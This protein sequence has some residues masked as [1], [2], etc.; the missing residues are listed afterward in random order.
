VF[1]VALLLA[2]ILSTNAVAQDARPASGERLKAVLLAPQQVSA[3]KLRT[4]AADGN[5]AVVIELGGTAEAARKRARSAA[6]EVRKSPLEL[7]YWIEIARNPELA[8]AHPEWMAS[9]QGHQE[10]RRLFKDPPK[11]KADEVVKVFPWVPILYKEAFAAQLERVEK[12]LAGMPQPKGVF[13]ND[14]QGAPSACGC[15]NPLCRWTTDYG[16]IRTATPLGADASAR[17]VAAVEKLAPKADVIPVWVTEC[18]E[19]DGAKDG[20]CAGVGCF[21]GICW[22][23]YT[24]QLRPVA[25]HSSRLGVLVPFRAFQRDLPLYG[26]KGGWIGHAVKTFQT[27]PPRHKGKAIA[28]SRLITVLQGW[29]VTD[30]DVAAQL[31]ESQRAGVGGT[32]VSEVKIDQSFKPR[33]VKWK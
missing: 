10:W 31:R 7:Y 6:D 21:K 32:I 17:F 18:E 11:P 28:A 23:A 25:E 14:L 2:A 15:G 4:L 26:A 16:P 30:D 13:L 22:K 1:Q 27:M 3:E 5:N 20:L 24:A 8:N 19:H 33:I 29:D 9:L 12:L